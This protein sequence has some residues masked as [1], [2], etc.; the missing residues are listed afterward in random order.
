MSCQRG[1]EVCQISL[2]L[3]CASAFCI[4][5]TAQGRKELL[6][7]VC[8]MQ[9]TEALR[10]LGGRSNEHRRVALSA[11]TQHV[12]SG[13][14]LPE[15]AVASLLATLGGDG[16]GDGDGGGEDGGAPLNHSLQRLALTILRTAAHGANSDAG[17]DA[18]GRGGGVLGAQRER[19]SK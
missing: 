11:L 13:G 14:A 8:E 9:F 7:G 1:L 15:V 2:S 16:D 10:K 18:G 4:R 5:R 19:R 17:N 12:C 6:C 3:H